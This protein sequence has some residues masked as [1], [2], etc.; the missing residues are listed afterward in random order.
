MSI[1][2]LAYAVKDKLKEQN[3]PLATEFYWHDSQ[4]L[5]VNQVSIKP[6]E[7]SFVIND[8]Q[9]KQD[10]KINRI[11]YE[12]RWVT[13][14]NNNKNGLSFQL[15]FCIDGMH[16][17]TN[18]KIVDAWSE[19]FTNNFTYTE[20]GCKRLY[21]KIVPNSLKSWDNWK[22]YVNDFTQQIIDFYALMQPKLI[23]FLQTKGYTNLVDYPIPNENPPIMKELNLQGRKMYKI[24]HGTDLKK[25]YQDMLRDGVVIIHEDTKGGQVSIFRNVQKDDY[26]YLCAGSDRVLLIGQMAGEV[27]ADYYDKLGNYDKLSGKGYLQRKYNIVYNVLDGKKDEEVRVEKENNKLMQDAGFPSSYDTISELKPENLDLANEKIF[28]PYFGVKVTNIAVDKP[29]LDLPNFPL[30]RILYGAPGTGKTYNSISEAVKIV[31]EAVYEQNKGNTKAERRNIQ[32]EFNKLRGKG[33]IAFVTFHQNYSYED[34]MVGIKPNLTAGDLQFIENKGIFYQLCEKAKKD[35]ENPYVI[36]IDE[37]NRANISRVFGELIT[38]LEPDKRIGNENE[39]LVTL[40]N[41]EPDFGVPNN[42]YIIGTMNTADKS[43]SLL[44]IALRRRFEFVPYMPQYELVT[45]ETKQNLLKHLNTK[46]FE[47]KNSTDYLLGHGY[48]MGSEKIPILLKNKI[49]PLLMEYFLG[50]I[51]VVSELF[52]GSGFKV[53]FNT[54]EYKW[55]VNGE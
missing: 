8:K 12:I 47:L 23:E 51:D 55:K 49:I 40:P 2:E 18:A 37:I 39:L 53:E 41:G 38:L 6:K 24:S 22:N 10:G 15:L 43:I 33:R 52:E 50:K 28:E 44:D 32:D 31:S 42:L 29:K 9:F 4:H 26:F 21:K 13:N 34:F 46:I 35:K 1:I 48:F 14:S 11:Y 3:H 36:I 25:H 30:N 27:E 19:N 45:D 16:H 54:K 7:H 17:N 5:P 20:D